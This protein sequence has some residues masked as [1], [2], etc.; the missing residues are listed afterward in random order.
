M[1]DTAPKTPTQSPDDVRPKTLRGLLLARELDSNRN[2]L[3]LSTRELAAKMQMST[4]MLNRVMTGRRVPTQLEIGGLCALLDIPAYR[5]PAL[6]KL[7]RTA[8]ETQWIV[9]HSE[10]SRILGV[11]EGEARNIT[12]VY[13]SPI[14][15]PLRTERYDSSLPA[16]Q[17][18][19]RVERVAD[20][21]LLHPAT[22]QDNTIPPAVMREQLRH[23]TSLPE[24]IRLLPN[25]TS[26]QGAF[27]IV[28]IEHFH[29]IVWLEHATTTVILENPEV[30]SPY[31]EAASALISA[32]LSARETQDALL[33]LAANY[34]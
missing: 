6:Y 34:Q 21:Y 27:R 17:V 12:S 23:L 5:R 8:G 30:T 22:L 10:A 3:G 31:T 28:H 16:A 14:P 33:Q 7:V 26:T 1:T 9:H 25:G 19:S 29:P 15:T 11:L 18:P 20:T 32:A 2:R 4:A 13:P 24:A